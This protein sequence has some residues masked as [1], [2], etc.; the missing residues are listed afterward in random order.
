VPQKAV[1]TI[2]GTVKVDI[3]VNVDPNG[4]VSDASIESQGPSQYFANFALKAA[5][6]WK[7]TPRSD[8]QGAS[9]VWTLEFLFRQSGVEA[10]ASE[11]TH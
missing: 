4:S 10:T 9:S 11:E 2:S 1:R 8:G 3:R 5:K 6:A 7:F